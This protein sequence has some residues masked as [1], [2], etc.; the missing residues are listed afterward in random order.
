MISVNYTFIIEALKDGR[1]KDLQSHF[2]PTAAQM[3]QQG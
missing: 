3:K 1:K 2:Q